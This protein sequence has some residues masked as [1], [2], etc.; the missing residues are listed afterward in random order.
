MIDKLITYNNKINSLKVIRTKHPPS[1]LSID[2]L[3]SLIKSSPLIIS[4][5]NK[6]FVKTANG[7]IVLVMS[8]DFASDNS[9][10]LDMVESFLDIV[11]NEADNIISSVAT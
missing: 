5:K 2:T 3:F 7:D 6:I 9:N 11:I 1:V 4:N 8:Q 10:I